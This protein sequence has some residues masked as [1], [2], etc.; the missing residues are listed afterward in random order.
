MLLVK[1][2]EGK[3]FYKSISTFLDLIYNSKFT[4]HYFQSLVFKFGFF[5]FIYVSKK[6]SIKPQS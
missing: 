3:Y 2:N 1:R 5:K 6:T 4:N